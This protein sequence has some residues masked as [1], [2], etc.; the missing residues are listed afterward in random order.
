MKKAGYPYVAEA[1]RRVLNVD[2]SGMPSGMY[3]AI[4]PATWDEWYEEGLEI[5]E[6]DKPAKADLEAKI[7]EIKAERE[8]AGEV[9]FIVDVLN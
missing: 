1:V 9:D 2:S 5:F 7:A 8:A 4:D 3:T 6:G